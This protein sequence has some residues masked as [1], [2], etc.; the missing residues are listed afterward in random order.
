MAQGNA[1]T[2]ERG[3]DL[4]VQDRASLQAMKARIDMLL[5]AGQEKAPDEPALTVTAVSDTDHADRHETAAP[6]SMAISEP[7]LAAGAERTPPPYAEHTS[8]LTPNKVVPTSDDDDTEAD[9]APVATPIASA[10]DKTV[11]VAPA[12]LSPGE[13]EIDSNTKTAPD[14]ATLLDAKVAAQDVMP[15]PSTSPAA[16]QPDA[17]QDNLAAVAQPD[18]NGTVA[19]KTLRSLEP[20]DWAMDLD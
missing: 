5:G 2:L 6:G 7:E 8:S 1:Q 13:I 14:P 11:T 9:E 12:D 20:S 17:T 4:S 15:T 18:P 10:T 3:Q 19:H 16:T